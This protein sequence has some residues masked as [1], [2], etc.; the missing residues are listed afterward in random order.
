MS[1]P[2]PFQTMRSSNLWRACFTP[3]MT[4]T[5]TPWPCPGPVLPTTRTTISYSSRTKIPLG[6]L[7]P[8]QLSLRGPLAP[9][10]SCEWSVHLLIPRTLLRTWKD[11]NMNNLFKWSK[12]KRIHLRC[13]IYIFAHWNWIWNEF[14]TYPKSDPHTVKSIAL[15]QPFW[16]KD[17]IK[18]RIWHSIFVI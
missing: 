15:N 7:H 5:T 8:S 11:M 14:M 13:I 6:L 4:S 2:W 10:L 18:M 17:R 9:R 16:I 3:T 1:Q 12:S